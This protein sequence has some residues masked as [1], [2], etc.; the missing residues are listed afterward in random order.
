MALGRPKAPLVLTASERQ[1]VGRVGAPRPDVPR[2]SPGE[3]ASC[4]PVR[5][6]S[7]TKRLRRSLRRVAANGWSSGGPA[8]SRSGWMAWWTSRAPGPH[9]R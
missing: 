2:R 6:A 9:G 5:A 7:T 4:W 3:R 1:T 8:F